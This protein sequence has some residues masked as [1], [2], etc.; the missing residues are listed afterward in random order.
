MTYNPNS[1]EL[2]FE[3]PTEWYNQNAVTNLVELTGPGFSQQVTPDHK[4][5][6]Y[7]PLIDHYITCEAQSLLKNEECFVPLA[8]VLNGN[9]DLSE[10]YINLLAAYHQICHGPDFYGTEET[11]KKLYNLCCKLFPLHQDSITVYYYMSNIRILNLPSKLTENAPCWQPELTADCLSWS[12]QTI[13]HYLKAIRVWK[14]KKVKTLTDGYSCISYTHATWLQTLHH[15]GGKCCQLITEIRIKTT[16]LICYTY[17]HLAIWKLRQSNKISKET[18][19]L[20]PTVSTGFFL[21]RRKGAI[22]VTGNT[23]Y[24]RGP[25]SLARSLKCTVKAAK[26]FQD[27]WF[28]IH[29]AIKMWHTTTHQK[30]EQ[31]GTLETRWGRKMTWKGRIDQQTLYKALEFVPYSTVADT[32]NKGLLRLW[33]H[34]DG[35]IQLLCQVN[36]SIVFQLPE[37]GFEEHCQ[38]LITLIQ[39][40]I[41]YPHPLIIPVSVKVSRVS[42]GDLRVIN[43]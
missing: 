31:D 36:N 43:L 30:L 33:A 18:R 13:Q 6:Y 34:Y 26:A 24:G 14:G 37:K 22:S 27:R 32:I 29:P 38:D 8:G 41:P 15:M 21:V 20:C 2:Q 9:V 39:V 25:T 16:H 7:T 28:D 35:N 3:T 4:M 42:W 10:D 40:P 23:N 5:V 1:R 17:P 12:Q 19:L 11:I